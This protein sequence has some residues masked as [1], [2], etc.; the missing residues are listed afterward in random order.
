MEPF[1]GYITFNQLATDHY[2]NAYPMA[3]S[4]DIK[5]AKRVK[6][7][8]LKFDSRAQGLS[9]EDFFLQYNRLLLELQHD[10]SQMDESPVV[11]L[12]AAAVA[13]RREKAGLEAY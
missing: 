9:P 12:S 3:A 8:L 6:D 2:Y 1:H 13:E 5:S 11:S 4:N 7:S 10:L